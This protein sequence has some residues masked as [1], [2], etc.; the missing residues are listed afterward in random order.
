[1][2]CYPS[3]F[4]TSKPWQA[5]RPTTFRVPKASG[6]KPRHRVRSLRAARL[7]VGGCERGT[8]PYSRWFTLSVMASPYR[9]PAGAALSANPDSV[10]GPA[11][12]APAGVTQVRPSIEMLR[13][14]VP[15]LADSFI[16]LENQ[17]TPT[18][19]MI[20]ERAAVTARTTATQTVGPA[21]RGTYR[22]CVLA[23]PVTFSWPGHAAG[24]SCPRTPGH[25]GFGPLQGCEPQ[26]RHRDRP[27]C[28]CERWCY[29]DLV[30]TTSRMPVRGAPSATVRLTRT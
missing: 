21:R 13:S 3:R 16:E 24:C 26:R 19:A 14:T 8:A 18:A 22:G 4:R 7:R 15:W 29:A 6:R 17:P 23:A 12:L 28:A 25:D 2:A 5:M 10:E 1:L 30:T 20:A 9:S 27:G 11:L